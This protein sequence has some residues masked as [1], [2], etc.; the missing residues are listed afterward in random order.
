[1]AKN[2]I[3][4]ETARWNRPWPMFTVVVT[5]ALLLRLLYLYLANGMAPFLSP[6]MDAEIYRTWADA[7]VRG[8][9]PEGTYFRAPFYP[10]LIALLG[11]LL[12]GDTFFPI[13]VLQIL[14]STI[15]AGLLALL[16]RAWFG[17]AAGWAAG[18]IWAG[19][20][21]SIYFDNEGL[22]ASLFT[23]GVI[24]LIALL[25]LDRKLQRWWTLALPS[26][27]LG[28]LTGLWATALVWWPVLLWTAWQRTSRDV[29]PSRLK[30]LVAPLASLLLM[31][32]V[33]SPILLHNLRQGGGF[34]ISTQ[35]G[36]NLF[37]GNHPGASGAFAVDPD[38]GKDWT[39]AEVRQR[40]EHLVGHTLDEA[41][42][43]RFYT[44]RAIRYWLETPGNALVLTGK[45]LLLLVNGREIANNRPLR[46]FIRDVHPFFLV[47]SVIGFPLICILGLPA[48]METWK[49]HEPLRPTLLLAATHALALL[50]FFITAR[51]RFPL[52]PALILLSGFTIQRL[53]DVI[54]GRASRSS[55]FPLLGKSALLALIVLVPE[56]IGKIDEQTPYEL[57]KGHAELRLGNLEN[58][59]RVYRQLLRKEYH[60]DAA[61]NLAVAL[62]HR[63]QWE[64]ADVVLQELTRRTP[65]NSSAWNNLGVVNEELFHY[66]RA[67]ICY[68]NAL[69]LN[70]AHADA[71]FNAVRLLLQQA[72]EM[73]DY[74]QDTLAAIDLL[75]Q[76]VE[77]QPANP[78]LRNRLARLK[79]KR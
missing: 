43:S 51:Y 62:I 28:L 57:H 29:H 48:A 41:G 19:F 42:V 77:L 61:L 52:A 34:T 22:I 69:A 73:I 25:E 72:D 17:R 33:V 46:P 71:R 32:A 50:A 23:T 76:A 36:I 4:G 79:S 24:Y 14:L 56:P 53:T 12:N 20:G 66:D 31:T 6:G 26:L 10:Q 18:L 8:A 47:L 70:P 15:A 38:F 74:S 68:R 49:R 40:A 7:I 27:L 54:Q 55:L 60:P 37:L 65:R 2:K 11:R 78:T 9:T 58:A 44:G 45:K 16:A 3:A 75:Q 63:E 39:E 1:M 67:L 35:G 21:M 64:E 30:R 5:T 59:E 13:R